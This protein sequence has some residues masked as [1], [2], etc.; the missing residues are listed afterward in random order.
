[1][2]IFSLN[3]PSPAKAMAIAAGQY[4]HMRLL[5]VCVN[6]CTCARILVCVYVDVRVCSVLH[7]EDDL[8]SGMANP[9]HLSALLPPNPNLSPSLGTTLKL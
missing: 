8:P 6:A 5:Y 1:V 7:R 2:T 9:V 4:K 3:Q